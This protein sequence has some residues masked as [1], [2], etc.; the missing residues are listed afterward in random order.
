MHRTIRRRLPH[1]CEV[2]IIHHHAFGDLARYVVGL[3]PPRL[4]VVDG[5]GGSGKS[6][7]AAR[8]MAATEKYAKTVVVPVDDFYRPAGERTSE[9]TGL[10]GLRRLRSE[11]I[12]P[13]ISGE[14]ITYRPY[15]WEI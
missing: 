11:V 15:D 7:F 5:A 1:F 10:F 13:Y 6:V 3:R 9:S 8:L 12:E 2:T 14:P 4:V